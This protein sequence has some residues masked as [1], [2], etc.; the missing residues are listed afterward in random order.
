[1]KKN[2]VAFMYD[3][4]ETL[5][6]GYMQDHALIPLL[7]YNVGEFWAEVNQYGRDNNMDNVLAYMHKIVQVANEKKIKIDKKVMFNLAKGIHYFDGVLEWFDRIN[8]FGKQLNLNIEHYIISSGM[9][10]II[11][12]TEIYSKFKNIFACSYVYDKE[13]NPIWPCQAVNYTNKTQYLFRIRKNQMDDL[14]NTVGVNELIE[15]E[16]KLPYKN[17]FYFGDGMTDIPCMKLLKQKGGNSFAVYSPISQKAKN[18]AIKLYKDKRVN[19]FAPADYTENSKLDKIVKS[20][21]IKLSE[22]F[23]IANEVNN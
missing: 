5:S 2:T 6:H 13:G 10:E 21:L 9:K 14:N 19:Y 17:M 12:G 4:D 23:K 11:E 1:M 20:L 7:G 18:T 8:E 3:F 22:D 15:E 16:E